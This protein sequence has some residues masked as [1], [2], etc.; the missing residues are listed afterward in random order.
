MCGFTGYLL[1][2]S[3]ET[4]IS[5]IEEMLQLQKHRGH[6]D[7]G[8]IGVNVMNNSISIPL[9]NNFPNQPNLTWGFNRLSILDLSAAG[10]QPMLSDSKDIALMMNGEVYNAFDDKDE[11]INLG[12]S[13]RGK[14]DTEV[15]LNIYLAFDDALDASVKRQMI[16][17]VKLGCQ[18]SGGVDSSLVAAKA[19]D[20]I[21]SGKLECVSL[22]F[23]DP[24]FSEKNYMNQV[25]NKLL[26]KSHQV[27]LDAVN[28]LS[29]INEAT[30]HF[31]QPLNH[32]NT[33]GIK[34][35]SKE[36]RKHVTVLLSGEGAD[37]SF[38]GYGR[39]NP[40]KLV[41][42]QKTSYR[43]FSKIEKIHCNL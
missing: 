15:V 35:L 20:Q 28:Y 27:Q 7:S 14:S 25:V 13:F 29:L 12:F 11:L 24:K 42:F 21:E 22:F 2:Q 18:L 3:I 31:E 37:E 43:A 36:A 9:E 8:I 17:D 30:G 23:K 19:K 5:T 4:S 1:K 33:I 39:F 16:S 41:F 6:D 32:P 40:K 10:H 26:L 34:L 38:G